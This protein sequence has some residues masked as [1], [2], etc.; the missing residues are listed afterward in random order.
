LPE[1]SGTWHLLAARLARRRCRPNLAMQESHENESFYL[2]KIL[3]A[4][5]LPL[6]NCAFNKSGD[7][8]ITGSY[9]RTCK[10]RRALWTR[11]CLGRGATMREASGSMPRRVGWGRQAV[12]RPWC[13]GRLWG[14]ICA[15]HAALLHSQS[16]PCG[17]GIAALDRLV[18]Q[19]RKKP[20]LM[21]RWAAAALPGLALK[22][23][24]R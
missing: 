17:R 2:F 4:H 8:F 11:L 3:R 13:G 1:R 12:H 16:M 22:L 21:A 6:T 23:L 15:L 7:R 5:I 19:R 14:A 20:C 24:G 18:A 10:A 9:D